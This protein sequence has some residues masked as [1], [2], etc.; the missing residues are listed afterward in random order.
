M[1]GCGNNREP[2]PTATSAPTITPTIT[3]TPKPLVRIIPSGVEPQK[4]QLFTETYPQNNCGGVS[5]VVS[6]FRQEYSITYILDFGQELVLSA[7]G[8]AGIPGVGEV[9][10]GAAVATK[11]NVSYG[12]TETKASQIELK[13]REKTRVEHVLKHL[14]LLDRGTVIITV[15]SQD[16]MFSY[17]FPIGYRIELQDTVE[18]PCPTTAITAPLT[19]TSSE[20]FTSTEP[21]VLEIPEILPTPLPVTIGTITVPGNSNL[22]IKFTVPQS[23]RYIFKY[24][25][26]SY[27]TYPIDHAPVGVKTWLT[28]IRIFKN[29]DVEWKGEAISDLSDARAAEYGYSDTAAEAEAKASGNITTLS[30]QKDDYII[31]V[32]VDGQ[33]YY[34][35]N[36]GEVVFEVQYL[37][38]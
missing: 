24:I 12:S 28:A 13:T 14:E 7:D 8:S 32:A 34:S 37:L 11:Y 36:P 9:Q 3:P 19:T 30:L 23:G 2:E 1:S 26:G 18:I 25:S 5:E 38:E 27:S 21:A 31:L 6:T 16:H 33:P 22:G 10:I 4:R 29:R 35:D 15:G 20:I 17:N